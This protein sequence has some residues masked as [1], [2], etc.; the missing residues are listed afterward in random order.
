MTAAVITASASIVV[1]VIVFILNQSAHVAAERR[2]EHLERINAQLRELYGPL[3][4]L[5]DV[6]ERIWRSLRGTS[7]PSQ[8]FR[9]PTV[10]LTEDQS[11]DWNLWLNN[12]LMPAN[13]A[14]RDLIL[15]HAELVI[16]AEMPEPLRTFCAHV[17]AYEVFLAYEGD[18]QSV[19]EAPLIRHPGQ[20]YMDYINT[21]FLSLKL[22]RDRLLGSNRPK[23]IATPRDAS[24]QRL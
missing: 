9:R 16:E 6:N 11:R 14:M 15:H 19:A 1:A 13:R 20:P 4:A 10:Q 2:R 3:H 12:A 7:L 24:G 5:A 18:M 23:R 8:D 22:E 17:A 21:S